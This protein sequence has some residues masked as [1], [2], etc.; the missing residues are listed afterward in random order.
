MPDPDK[1][2]FKQVNHRENLPFRLSMIWQQDED[3]VGEGEPLSK[4]ALSTEYE[5]I[6]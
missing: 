1:N 6:Q 5:H 4:A 3:L 2:S